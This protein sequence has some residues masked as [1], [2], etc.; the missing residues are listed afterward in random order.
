MHRMKV[1]P[2]KYTDYRKFLRDY[3]NGSAST[4]RLVCKATGIKSAGHLSLIL[5]GKVNISDL[6]ADKFAGFC[7]LK[8]QETDYFRTLVRFNQEEKANGRSNS[9]SS[10]ALSEIHRYTG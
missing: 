4:Y 5:N 8:K 3:F 9:S 10:S 6:Q 7:N 2:L 1:S